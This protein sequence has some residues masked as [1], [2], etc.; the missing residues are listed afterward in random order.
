MRAVWSEKLSSQMVTS[1]CGAAQSEF[2]GQAVKKGDIRRQV[3]SMEY[4]FWQ[5]RIG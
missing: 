2:N 4:G 5:M 1:L 3:F